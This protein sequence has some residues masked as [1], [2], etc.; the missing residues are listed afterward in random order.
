MR[1]AKNVLRYLA[2]LA[3]SIVVGTAWHEV[4]GHGLT[5]VLCGGKITYVE[6]LGLRLWPTLGWVGWQ[7]QYGYCNTEGVTTA[8]AERVVSLAGSV[9]T[10]CVAVASTVLLW[11]RRW[12]GWALRVL[13][14]LSLWW[15]DLF[16]YTLPSWGWRRSILWGRVYSEPYAAAVGLGIPGWAFQGA[17]VGTSLILA[18][19][20]AVRLSRRAR[21]TAA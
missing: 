16:T 15:V 20:L 11:T 14:V 6:T 10:W 5:A 7:G 9:S 8:R 4:V 3:L 18:L 17:V 21:Q 19:A 1:M 12:R 2:L 13:V